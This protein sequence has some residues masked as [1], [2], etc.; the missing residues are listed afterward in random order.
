MG[1]RGEGGQ[2]GGIYSH[3]GRAEGGD[4]FLPMVSAVMTQWYMASE[5]VMLGSVRQK[6]AA[7]TNCVAMMRMVT[8]SSS[9]A[10]V[11]VRVRV[12]PVRI[13]V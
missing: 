5:Y 10:R 2:K 4:I 6:K 13:E 11:R 3:R 7:A 8:G 12:P 1:G 9:C